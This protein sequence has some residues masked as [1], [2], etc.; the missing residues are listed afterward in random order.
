MPPG[1]LVPVD[2]LL[3]ELTAAPE[4]SSPP[5]T[6]EA[7]ANGGAG[8]TDEKLLAVPEVAE[9]FGLSEDWLYRHW[10]VVGGVKLGRKVLRFP[11]S[12]LPRYLAAQH[13]AQHAA[14][15]KAP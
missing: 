5:A 15:R 13:A 4:R 8:L 1:P 3:V 7:S 9:R 11:A 12:A 6:P 2:W 10:K 14:Q